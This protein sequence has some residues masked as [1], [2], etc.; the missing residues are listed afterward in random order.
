MTGI[1]C[2]EIVTGAGHSYTILGEIILIVA[3][4]YTCPGSCQKKSLWAFVADA[5]SSA[6]NARDAESLTTIPD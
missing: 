4:V 6:T 3:V 5:L 1:L 2:A